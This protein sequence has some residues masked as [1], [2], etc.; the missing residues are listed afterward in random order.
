MTSPC[1][2]ST[3]KR[4]SDDRAIAR[5]A[6]PAPS[7]SR[8]RPVRWDET[9]AGHERA[10]LLD[11]PQHRRDLHALEAG[12]RPDAVRGVL[13]QFVE[14]AAVRDG[15]E[16][17]GPGDGRGEG[18]VGF[19]REC[20][21]DVLDSRRVRAEPKVRPSVIAQCGRGDLDI[22]VD[23]AAPASSISARRRTS[24]LGAPHAVFRP[25]SGAAS[26]TSMSRSPRPHWA[27]T[28]GRTFGSAR[29]RRLSLSLVHISEPTR[30]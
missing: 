21:A 7:A 29:T 17:V 20:A 12:Q 9:L 28:L 26:S 27:I 8:P 14:V 2:C 3:R 15:L 6:E 5:L 1:Y 19:L 25:C 18:Y 22:D 4:S 11:L 10:G 30:P 13:E 23:D 16:V 24:R